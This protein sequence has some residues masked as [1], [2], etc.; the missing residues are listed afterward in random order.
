M[1]PC[2]SSTHH[3]LCSVQLPIISCIHSANFTL[4]TFFCYRCPL[5]IA[6]FRVFS[7]FSC[8]SLQ[9]CRD[10]D[11]DRCGRESLRLLLH[12][13]FFTTVTCSREVGSESHHLVHVCSIQA[14]LY[15]SHTKWNNITDGKHWHPKFFMFSEPTFWLPAV[16]RDL[17]T[18]LAARGCWTGHSGR[19]DVGIVWAEDGLVVRDQPH[20]RPYQTTQFRGYCTVP[21]W[22]LDIF[23]SWVGQNVVDE[24]QQPILWNVPHKWPTFVTYLSTQWLEWDNVP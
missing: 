15:F 2:T 20:E 22:Q 19:N 23:C 17:A 13:P 12:V 18:E 4:F 7:V 3:S 14:L 6:I 1:T 8:I 11:G 5:I 9:D 10:T 16:G 24:C 21:C